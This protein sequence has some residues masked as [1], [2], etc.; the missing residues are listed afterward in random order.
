[1]VVSGAGLSGGSSLSTPQIV[2]TTRREYNSN[3][4]V[5]PI[6]YRWM[7]TFSDKPNVQVTVNGIPSACN[8]DC[9]YT[10]LEGVPVVGAASL[11]GS[12]LSITLANITGVTS[13]LNDIKVTLDNQACND[14][15]GTV[16][17][18]TCS[19]PMNPDSTPILTAGSHFPVIKV[20]QIG[21]VSIDTLNVTPINVNLAISAVSSPKGGVNG[22]Y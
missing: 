6:D 17:S 16:S 2:A 4:F 11:Y 14:L 3:L 10:F 19:L 8:T 15:A 20:S 7:K 5:D 12:T 1:M 21:I 18:F 22:G 13:N 9:R